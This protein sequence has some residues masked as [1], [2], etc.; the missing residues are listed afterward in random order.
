MKL[1]IIENEIRDGV[2][3]EPYAG[4]AGVALDLLMDEYCELV[5]I[6]DL[7]RSIYAFWH[8]VLFETELLCEKISSANLTIEEWETQRR[9]QKQKV[10][11]ELLDLGFSTFYLNRTNVSGIIDGGIIGGKRQEGRWGIDARFNRANL[12]DRIRKIASYRDRIIINNSDAI[13][14]LE[15][16]KGRIGHNSLTYLDPPYYVQGKN[17][18]ANFYDEKDHKKI[19]EYMVG[20]SFPWI[21][22]Y[23]NENGIRELYK[24]YRSITY[25]INYSAGDTYKG[26]EVIFFAPDLIIP[27]ISN[28][29]KLG[30]RELHMRMASPIIF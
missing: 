19:A 1:F 24:R 18:Y 21:V 7:D 3:I 28:P 26:R 12:S 5:Y 9:I 14:F 30:R 15:S 8:S 2:Y 29:V 25:D 10:S 22:S 20:Y 4:G 23:D 11:A 16:I 17:L 6:N 27:A 13:E